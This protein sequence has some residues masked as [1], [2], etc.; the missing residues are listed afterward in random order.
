MEKR[1]EEGHHLYDLGRRLWLR[2]N[3]TTPGEPE[4]PIGRTTKQRTESHAKIRTAKDEMKE[5]LGFYFASL[6]LIFAFQVIVKLGHLQVPLLLAE[7]LPF[8]LYGWGMPVVALLAYEA[9]T[10]IPLGRP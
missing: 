6:A 2:Q 5:G 7:I 1:D 9:W 3:L 4:R 10:T 8:I